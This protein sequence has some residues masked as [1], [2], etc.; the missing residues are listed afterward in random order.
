MLR[1]A[2]ARM[3]LARRIS[4]LLRCVL[5]SCLVCAASCRPKQR[6]ICL[7]GP[8]CP[9]AGIEPLDDDASA[10]VVGRGQACATQSVRAMRGPGKSVDVIFVVDNSSSMDQEIAAVRENI[11][12]NFA[13]IVSAG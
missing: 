5:L 9:D 2:L 11:N 6:T 1:F 7:G 12:Q 13:A 4:L 3:R 8:R 10:P